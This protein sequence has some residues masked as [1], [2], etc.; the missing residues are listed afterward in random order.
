M[1]RIAV[2][3][4]LLGACSQPSAAPSTGTLATTVAPSASSLPSH[5]PRTSSS[6]L[7]AT[8]I[9]L[10]TPASVTTPAA[11]ATRIVT[12]TF[13]D[14]S[15]APANVL[16][17]LVAGD[18]LF[19]SADAGDSWEE[20]RLPPGSSTSGAISFVDDHEGW[21]LRTYIPATACQQQGYEL[22]HTTDAAASWARLGSVDDPYFGPLGGQCKRTMTFA[23]PLHAVVVASDPYT[24]PTIYRTAD[25]GATW[26]LARL[27]PAG[28]VNN[29]GNELIPGRV[30]WVGSTLIVEAIVA[31]DENRTHYIFRSSDGGAS[32]NVVATTTDFSGTLG[33][34]TATRWLQIRLPDASRETTDA[35]KTWHQFAS[36]YSQAAPI[37]P[38]LIF[39]DAN[40]G[41]ATVRGSV[42][43][44]TD[45]GA[46][47]TLLTTPY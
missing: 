29:G 33:L 46:H 39:A 20:H 31:N 34:P 3:F 47:W 13:V 17:L 6:A 43:R 45:G 16:W 1:R 18:H 28:Y 36:D 4:L 27:A 21:Y 44:T 7:A 26:N 11:T 41:Y 38:W 2:V 10:A 12:P 37:A 23:D 32:W 19:R 8:Q 30:R 25:G 35:G 15:A 40:V 9:P 22:W 5:G 24:S 14:I 42:Q